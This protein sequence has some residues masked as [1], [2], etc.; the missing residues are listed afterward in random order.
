[1]ANPRLFFVDL[2]CCYFGHRALDIIGNFVR[3][4]AMIG[5]RPYQCGFNFRL[6]FDVSCFR[7]VGQQPIHECFAAAVIPK[8]K[9]A[10][11]FVQFHIICSPGEK[12]LFRGLPI[13]I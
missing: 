8:V 1:M 6:I 2:R 3:T 9:R 11:C 12:T 5:E 7:D 13:I 4:D 10:N